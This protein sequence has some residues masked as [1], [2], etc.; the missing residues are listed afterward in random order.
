MINTARRQ[1]TNTKTEVLTYE[2]AL[3]ALGSWLDSQRG[4]AS[5]RVM[6]TT[7]GFLVQDTSAERPDVETSRTVTFDDVWDLSED[8]RFRKR[9]KDVLGGYQNVLRAVGF[10]FDEAGARSILLEQVEDDLILTYLY[11]LYSGGHSLTKQF[12]V[13]APNA[14]RDLVS[15]ALERRKPGKLSRGFLRLLGDA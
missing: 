7:E 5:I 6:E 8:K 15:G 2:T 9:S 4:I 14:K 11:P 12:T 1:E 3:R 10:E 13:L